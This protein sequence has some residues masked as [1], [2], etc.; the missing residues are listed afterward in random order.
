[1]DIPPFIKQF[2]TPEST[3]WKNLVPIII[4]PLLFLLIIFPATVTYSSVFVTE[5]H[6]TIGTSLPHVFLKDHLLSQWNNQWIDGFPEVS[7]PQSDRYYPLSLLPFYL[8]FDN[9]F[10]INGLIL[11]HLFIGY[12]AFYTFGRLITK[13]NNLLMIAS[14]FYSFSGLMMSQVIQGHINI[15]YALA[16]TPLLYYFFIKLIYRKER[17]VLNIIS[18]SICTLLIFISGAVYY[19]IYTYLFIAIFLVYYLVEGKLSRKIVYALCGSIALFLLL[20]SIKII[21]NLLVMSNIIRNDVIDPLAGGG[22]LENNLASIIFGTGIHKGYQVL[23]FNFSP[24]ESMVLIG[25][26]PVF[27][28][29][30][31][32][33]YGRRD[34]IIP[35]FISILFAFV[36]ADGGKTVLSFI[37]FLPILDTFRSPGRIFGALLPII[38]VLAI[39]GFVIAS[40][41]IKN[42]EG[43]GLSDDR[44]RAIKIGVICLIGVKLLE[45]PYQEAAF[46]LQALL[47]VALIAGF[48][49]LLYTNRATPANLVYYSAFS[50]ITNAI[51]LISDFNLITYD[52]LL[53]SAL[54]SFVLIAFLLWMYRDRISQVKSN[55]L[56]ILLVLSLILCISANISYIKPSDPALDESP[57]LGIIQKMN[58][59]PSTNAQTWVYTNGWPIQHIDFTYWFMKNNIHPMR[60]YYSYYLKSS[61]LPSYRIG[62]VTYSTADYIIDTAYLENGNQNLE[63][64]TFK[65]DNL[66]VYKPDNVLPNAF[67]LRNDQLVPAAI[68]K[69]TPDEV[70]IEGQF[71]KGDI[72]IL[73]TAYYKGWKVNGVDATPAGNMV[74]CQLDSGSQQV[75]FTF[76]PIDFKIGLALTIFGLLVLVILIIKRTELEAWLNKDETRAA[77]GKDKGKDKGKKMRKK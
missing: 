46:S 24:H 16:W 53:K 12:L 2:Y 38:L 19:L 54:L 62:D 58:E 50:L 44:R 61:L 21:P 76:D 33:I 68:T 35:S 52:V 59:Y 36:W 25:I 60:A 56:G 10:V 77:K 37:H 66:S 34:I 45:L 3:I 30:I 64:Y 27:F 11:L 47:S 74:A 20:A 7:S 15:I 31:A 73:K 63:E 70:V 42:G 41:K 23:G 32:L 18:F 39:Y 9:I 49:A 26:I 6:D 67:V 43:F 55:Y 13:N 72:A 40:S 57:A 71:L 48:I 22:S 14:L 75:A 69:F 29:I 51:V 17:T 65:V 1:M 5:Y 8:I 4:I 28:M